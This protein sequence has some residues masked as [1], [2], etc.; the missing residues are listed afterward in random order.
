MRQ[1]ITKHGYKDP[2]KVKMM[3]KKEFQNKFKL[4]YG[5]DDENSDEEDASPEKS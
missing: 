5:Y 2:E 4:L 1:E 3:V